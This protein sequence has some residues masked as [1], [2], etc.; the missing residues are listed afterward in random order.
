MSDGECDYRTKLRVSSRNEEEED[1]DGDGERFHNAIQHDTVQC[2][3]V[4]EKRERR[5][6]S[7]AAHWVD[8]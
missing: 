1:D 6:V 3:T 5:K 2:N 4:E 7:K 8:D